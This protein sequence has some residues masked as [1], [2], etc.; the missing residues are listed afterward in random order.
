M[1]GGPASTFNP[2][3]VRRMTTID[4]SPSLTISPYFGIEAYSASLIVGLKKM[5]YG[6]HGKGQ[7]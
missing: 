2:V 3:L 4:Q 7:Q 5:R 1:F 6:L